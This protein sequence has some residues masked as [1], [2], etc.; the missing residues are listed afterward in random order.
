[1]VEVRL[2]AHRGAR[3][4]PGARAVVARLAAA[5]TPIAAPL[6]VVPRPAAAGIPGV[7]PVALL[8]G[9]ARVRGLEVPV[10][11]RAVA[12]IPMSPPAGSGTALARARG[13][14][15]VR[16]APVALRA[17]AVIPISPP[18]GS[19]TGLARARGRPVVRRP[20]VG[21]PGA[22]QQLLAMLPA[23][24]VGRDAVP[25]VLD[26]LVRAGR[27]PARMARAGVGPWGA[28]VLPA[29][30][31]IP[32][33][34]P[35]ARAAAVEGPARPGIVEIGAEP[36]AGVGRRRL[37]V[38]SPTVVRAA[39]VPLVAVPRAAGTP[40][41]PA[42]GGVRPAE[43]VASLKGATGG[44]WP[45]VGRRP[46]ATRVAVGSLA[47]QV[48]VSGQPLVGGPRA[49]MPRGGECRAAPVAAGAKAM[50]GRRGGPGRGAS[51]V[52]GRTG[53]PPAAVLDIPLAS[54]AGRDRPPTRPRMAA[55]RGR[56]GIV[57]VWMPTVRAGT[58]TRAARAARA[59]EWGGT[60]RSRLAGSVPPTAASQA[61]PVGRRRLRVSGLPPLAVRTT[62]P[63]GSGRLGPPVARRLAWRAEPTGLSGHGLIAPAGP[64]HGPLW[65]DGMTRAGG[66]GVRRERAVRV[67]P[68]P[69]GPRRTAGGGIRGTTDGGPVRTRRGSAGLAG[70]QRRAWS[71]RRRTRTRGNWHRTCGPSCGRS[72]RR[73][74]S[75]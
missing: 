25:P 44:A 67:G 4:G 7:A 26:P 48:V 71:N 38:G 10:A 74:P 18:G 61:P 58:R 41:V 40:R 3:A 32:I 6:L 33:G 28:V 68:V 75:G 55:R 36:P 37:T 8:A 21:T 14:P 47:P 46:V 27:A 17:V 72:P 60:K 50:T 66:R 31:G 45:A 62:R 20:V 29:A 49:G 43:A 63:A 19:R 24:T 30:A 59:V 57:P 5:G 15:V 12:I 73:W 11:L 56:P 64:V 39:A 1:M 52:G 9:P 65:T 23:A 34:R 54:R 42:T 13:R 53:R 69:G 51:R 70:R 22:A 16:R 2:V 35:A